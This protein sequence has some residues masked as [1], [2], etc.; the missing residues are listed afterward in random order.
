LAEKTKNESEWTPEVRSFVLSGRWL[1]IGVVPSLLGVLIAS[2]SS[3]VLGF[4]FH[5]ARRG[6]PRS[7]L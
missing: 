7:S 4:R 1:R 6:T 2:S 5:L 3:V